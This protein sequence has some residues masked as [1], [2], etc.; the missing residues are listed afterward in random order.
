MNSKP[1][2][3]LLADGAMGTYYAEKTGDFT[4]LPERANLS[5]PSLVRDIHREY[6]EAGA[7]LIRTNTFS[8]NRFL[9]ECMP[10][11]RN[12]VLKDAYTLAKQAA[13]G[14]D[15]IV[16][17]DLGPIPETVQGRPLAEAEIANEYAQMV[18]AFLDFGAR[19]FVFETLS[20]PAVVL[21]AIALIK[22][23]DPSAWV[24]AQFAIMPDGHTRKGIH[25]RELVDMLKDEPLLDAYGF[26]CGCGPAHLAGFIRQLDIGE[27]KP[28]SALPN[29]GYPEIVNERTVYTQKP[30]YFAEVLA[31]I[32]AHGATILGGCCGTT[33]RHIEAVARRLR[34]EAP[35]KK[36]TPAVIYKPADTPPP[37]ENPFQDKLTA[38]QFPIAVELD[39][40][41]GADLSALIAASRVLR[42]GGADIIT[43]SDS[44][45]SRV[46]MDAALT[47]V[48]LMQE[49][50]LATMPH[51]CCRDKNII[52]LKSQ[53]LATHAAGIRNILAVTGDGI[54]GDS[55][56]EVKGVFNTHSKGL[57]AMIREM[58][59]DVFS[60][61][62]FFV[63]GAF[64]INAANIDAEWNRVLEKHKAGASFFLTQFIFSE[65]AISFL[66]RMEKPEG[67]YILGGILPLVSYRNAV[68]M[69]QEIPGIRIPPE[70]VE[71]FDPDMDRVEAQ[72]VGTRLAVE[73]AEAIRPYVDGL[74]LMAPFNRADMAVDIISRIREGA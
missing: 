56:A 63:G 39:P 41:Y 18:Q 53:L 30:E 23:K 14:T 60:H 58:N 9:L 72:E 3:I 44:P 21:P 6:I 31:E 74:Y 29:A 51:F 8:A 70:V 17:A 34:E 28:F 68:F 73:M 65:E 57:I 13:E 66:K 52:A 12:M 43:I 2:Q 24:L 69:S 59:Q 48:L 47:S 5:E 11:V 35:A 15:V 4:G 10:V 42:Y 38:G 50:G 49:S 40:P 20:D 55:R 33:P 37:A 67:L 64:N 25:F 45:L 61:A 71:R 26:N 19:H 32:A 62:P 27:G 36:S 7:S 22:E 16:A 46:R 54:A 1:G